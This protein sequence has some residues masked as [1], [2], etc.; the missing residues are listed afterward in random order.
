MEEHTSLASYWVQGNILPC[1]SVIAWFIYRSAVFLFLWYFVH[2]WRDATEVCFV[3]CTGSYDRFIKMINTWS[4][5][6]PISS[7]LLVTCLR[8]LCCQYL[9]NLFFIYTLCGWGTYTGFSWRYIYYRRHS[10]LYITNSFQICLTCNSTYWIEYYFLCCNNISP[11]YVQSQHKW[12][13]CCMSN[14][15][16]TSFFRFLHTKTLCMNLA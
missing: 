11:Y 13:M 6:P 7:V 9:I 8:I 1:F 12:C 15:K 14:P 4:N 3:H 2:N 10:Y 5:P 16:A